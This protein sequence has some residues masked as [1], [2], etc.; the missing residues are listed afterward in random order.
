MCVQIVNVCTHCTCLYIYI[1][2]RTCPSRATFTYHRHAEPVHLVRTCVLHYSGRIG[3][4]GLFWHPEQADLGR[5]GD[6]CH[7]HPGV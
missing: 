7:V 4:S 5:A 3:A 6:G 2:V 1:D